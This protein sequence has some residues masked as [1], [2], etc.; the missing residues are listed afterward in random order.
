METS[1]VNNK[2]SRYVWGGATEVFPN[3]LGWWERRIFTP[4][5]SD[6][7]IEITPEYDRRPDLLAFDLFGRDFYATLILQY[8]SILDINTEFVTGAVLR[9]PSRSRVDIDIVGR[10]VGGVTPDIYLQNK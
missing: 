2:S 10:P 4:S 5:D 9:I 3:R 7:I 1:S 6:R 8:N